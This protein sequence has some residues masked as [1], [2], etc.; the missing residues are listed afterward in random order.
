MS[1]FQILSN[2]QVSS[3]RKSSSSY[4]E[5][6]KNLPVAVKQADGTFLGNAVECTK[7]GEVQSFGMAAKN[8]GLFIRSFKQEDGKWRIVRVNKEDVLVRAA[9]KATK[10]KSAS[11][12]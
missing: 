12:K 9:R 11:K 3:S 10:T 2:V 8:N 4:V 5:T 1:T 7:I 6:L